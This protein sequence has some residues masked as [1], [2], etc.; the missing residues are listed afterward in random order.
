MFVG[1][2][3]LYRGLLPSILGAFPY[4]G[5]SFVVYESCRPW[6]PFQNDD[7]GRPLKSATIL[8]GGIASFAGQV[9]SYP[10]DTC[11]RYIQVN[12]SPTGGT[13]SVWNV[14]RILYQQGGLRRFY[15]G[16]LPNSL[17]ILPG[18]TASFF[19]YEYCRI[20]ISEISKIHNIVSHSGKT[21]AG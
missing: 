2:R 19:A 3:G 15:R 21:G 10:M 17:K 7:Y 14:L 5:L 20:W 1:I 12:S 8:M 9:V 4:V 18:A 6:L 13:D 16:F 11:R